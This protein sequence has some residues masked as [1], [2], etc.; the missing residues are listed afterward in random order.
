MLIV[1]LLERFVDLYNLLLIHLVSR[2]SFARN[3]LRIP[4]RR[5]FQDH[6]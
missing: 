2:K 4:L 3:D 6:L 1:N 5:Y